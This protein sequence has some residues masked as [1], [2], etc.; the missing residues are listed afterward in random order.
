MRGDSIAAMEHFHGLRRDAYPHRLAQQSVRHGVVM[1][2]DLDMIIEGDFAFF[3]FRVDV[4]LD[5]QWLERGTFDL[6]EQRTPA[7]SQVPCHPVIELRG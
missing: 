4:R 1:V 6:I 7:R 2:F 5:G 3:P